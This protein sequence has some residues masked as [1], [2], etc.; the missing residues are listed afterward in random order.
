[1]SRVFYAENQE[2]L[3][4][5]SSFG[6]LVPTEDDHSDQRSADD[7]PGESC[8]LQENQDLFLCAGDKSPL[9]EIA[10]DQNTEQI[11]LQYGRLTEGWSGF[12]PRQYPSRVELEFFLGQLG[13]I[14]PIVDLA[15]PGSLND[16]SEE[17]FSPFSKLAQSDPALRRYREGSILF[18]EADEYGK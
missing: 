14:F 3:Q 7:S 15:V 17:W 10:N 12:V 4:R 8:G 16:E 5:K 1:M 11:Q 9:A 2:L 13:A 6:L 18:S